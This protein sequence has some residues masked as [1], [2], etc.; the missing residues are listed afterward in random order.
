M[1]SATRP[2]KQRCNCST[3]RTARMSPRRIVHEDAVLER[4]EAA[5]KILF[6]SRSGECR[7]ETQPSRMSRGPCG[8][9]AQRSSRPVRP[10]N[11]VRRPLTV[12]DSAAACCLLPGRP[13]LSR[14]R[15]TVSARRPA[16]IRGVRRTSARI[17]PLV[18]FKA[19]KKAGSF[20]TSHPHRPTRDAI[21]GS[22]CAACAKP[23][24][25]RGPITIF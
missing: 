3:S 17:A 12:T 23:G 11:P 5:Q 1:T 9:P 14:D 25:Q 21:L 19:R 13:Q 2:A 16:Q 7:F 4:P 18:L 24:H 6:S 8:C 10:A 15:G 20:R 22:L